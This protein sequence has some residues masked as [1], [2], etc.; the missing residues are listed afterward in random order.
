MIEKVSPAAYRKVI[1]RG[2][3]GKVFL[4]KKLDTQKYF[5]MKALKKDDIAAKNQQDHTRSKLTLSQPSAR[6]WKP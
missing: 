5:A 6:S 1:G 3:F 4:V 2:T